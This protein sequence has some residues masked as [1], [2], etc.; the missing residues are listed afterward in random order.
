MLRKIRADMK[1]GVTDVDCYKA[2]FEFEIDALKKLDVEVIPVDQ[3]KKG[4][5]ANDIKEDSKALEA[6]LA[7]R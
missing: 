6:R 5:I 1:A 4:H 2:F 7:S 3:V